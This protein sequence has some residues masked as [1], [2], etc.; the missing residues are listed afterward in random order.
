MKRLLSH[1]TIA[2]YLGALSVGLVSH[3]LN[4]G[5]HR[6]P[7]MY[8]LVW[9]MY[10]G[11]SAYE[12]RLHVIG[13]GVSG[14]YYQLTPSP[15]SDFHPHGSISRVHYDVHARFVDEMALMTLRNTRHEPIHRILVV[16]ECWSKKYNLPD[17]LWA[18]RF[19][20]EK[21]RHS[22]FHLRAVANGDGQVVRMANEWPT[23]MAQRCVMDNPRLMSD[24]TKGH[25]FLAVDPSYR[26][27]VVPASYQSG[28][29]PR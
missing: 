10:C 29:P 11:W 18:Q 19:T 15:W 21:E 27:G 13:E 28:P 26:Q 4:W 20:E 17:R 25:Q 5:K 16:E 24:M 22:Y 8:F 2:V 6:H 14:E 23:V 3:T 1:V 12:S 7:V 9:D